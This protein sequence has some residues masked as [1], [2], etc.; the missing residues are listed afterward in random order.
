MQNERKSSFFSVVGG[1]IKYDFVYVCG[2]EF[3]VC[4]DVSLISKLIMSRWV[5]VVNG[6]ACICAWICECVC[7]CVCVRV[8]VCIRMSYSHAKQ[9]ATSE[10]DWPVLCM[11]QR[12]ALHVSRSTTSQNLNHTQRRMRK[13]THTHT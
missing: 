10:E 3:F 1:V 8:V 7:V 5:N 2:G 4:S 11:F 9:L 12:V 6:C 13:N